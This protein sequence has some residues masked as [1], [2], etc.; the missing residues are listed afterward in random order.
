M[1]LVHNETI[2]ETLEAVKCELEDVV[3][4]LDLALDELEE[5]LES[6]D[7]D[8]KERWVQKAVDLIKGAKEKL[9]KE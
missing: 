4:D 5:A 8:D 6:G 2:F 3:Y 9:H 7:D 1:L